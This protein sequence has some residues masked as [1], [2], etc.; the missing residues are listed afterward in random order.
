MNIGIYLL[1]ISALVCEYVFMT[2]TEIQLEMRDFSDRRLIQEYI[3]ERGNVERAIALL[4][5][6]R[7][8]GFLNQYGQ[9]TAKYRRTMDREDLW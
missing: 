7:R 5:E 6:Y 1:D 4:A 9:T 3:A 8:R 2:A